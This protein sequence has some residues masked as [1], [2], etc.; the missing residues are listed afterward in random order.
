MFAKIFLLSLLSVAIARPSLEKLAEYSFE[1][2]LQDFRLKFSPDEI[3]FRRTLFHNELAR[4]VSHNSK[5]LS[6]KENVNRFTVMTPAEKK[7]YHGR[8]KNHA[9]AQEKSLKYGRELPADF[10]LR[11]TSE[12]PRMVD[13]RKAGIV[14]PVK[15]QGHC[16]SCW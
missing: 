16:G 8:S 13:W 10:T 5:N 14:S 9:K 15:D 4:I 2:F 11:P 7:T 3:N 6:W 1:Q 12:L